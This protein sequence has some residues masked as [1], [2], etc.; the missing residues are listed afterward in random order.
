MCVHSSP[1]PAQ[2][3]HSDS[4][5]SFQKCLSLYSYLNICLCVPAQSCLT[6]C[7]PMDYSRPGSSVHGILQA[8]NTGVACRALLQ[9]IFLTQVS[10]PWLLCLLHCRRVRYPLSHLGNPYICLSGTL[11]YVSCFLHLCL[12]N[13]FLSANTSLTFLSFF[14]FFLMLQSSP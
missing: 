2:D 3:N 12:K 4:C 6:L 8:K 1:I 5:V 14:L 10:N 13:L 9:G 11:L 7:V